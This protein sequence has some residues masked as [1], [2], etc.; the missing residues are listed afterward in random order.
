MFY[1]I[2]KRGFDLL[3]ALMAVTVLL[4][5]F[6]IISV[7]I[8]LSSKGPI[9][10]KSQRIGRN[11]RPFTMLKFRSM[12]IKAEDSV[13]SARMVNAQR[14]FKLGDFLRKSKLDE[15]PQLFNILFGHMSIVGPRP[16]PRSVAEA[17]YKEDLPVVTSVRPG[18]ACLDSLYDYTH[19]E[20]FVK[21]EQEFVQKVVPV[22][23]AL[24]KMYVERKRIRL[25][26]YLI[27]RTVALMWQ[28]VVR[29]KTEFACDRYE[30]EAIA[31][32]ECSKV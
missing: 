12:H 19:G 6:L 1:R 14:I 13:E 17:L 16:Y 8:K 27:C 21:D 32:V 26:I 15:L 29:R 9:L 18:L 5:V 30:Q 10:Y 20:L 28:I 23:S 31:A 7:G 25:D 4:P 2:V 22:R 24:A 3:C 11:N